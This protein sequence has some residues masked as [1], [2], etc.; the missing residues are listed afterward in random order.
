MASIA[1]ERPEMTA[2][3]Q[4]VEALIRQCDS[5]RSALS[6]G[7]AIRWLLFLGLLAFTLGFGYLFWQLAQRLNG[8]AF[9]NQLIATAEKRLGERS[10][11]YLSEVRTLIDNTSPAV[12]EAFS[13]RINEDMPVVMQALQKEGD[14][15][16][17]DLTSQ[18][19]RTVENH[20]KSTLDQYQKQMIEEIP[21]L[22]DEQLR[23]RLSAN[24]VRAAEKASETYFINELE[25]RVRTL[26]DTWDRFP[27][28]DPEVTQGQRTADLIIG[29][30][31]EL[32]KQLMLEEERAAAGQ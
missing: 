31:F 14:A 29:E 26:Y 3:N 12:A 21:A 6:Q 18:V 13:A 5:L 24:L 1:P 17:A 2:T 28:A 4:Q 7:Q 30:L 22:E 15:L 20:L 27:A 10:D 32:T 23:E 8:E 19:R 16:V 25:S 9:R 11:Q